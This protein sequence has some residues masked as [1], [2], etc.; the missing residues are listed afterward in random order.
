MSLKRHTAYNIIGAIVPIAVSLLT[1]PAYLAAVGDARF[2]IL[3]V[4]W[5]LLG[6]FGLFD[7]GLG[8]ATSHHIAAA[9]KDAEAQVSRWFWSALLTNLLLGVIG[10]LIIW[11][12]AS[13]YFG[14]V[15]VVD[16]AMRAEMLAAVPWLVL[17]VPVA[18]VT[19][20]MSGVLQG[21]NRFGRLNF[22]SVTGTV[23]FQLLPLG[24]AFFWSPS[25]TILLP[26]SLAARAIS[27]IW[28]WK[29]IRPLIGT[30]ASAGFSR[31]RAKTMLRFGG[32]VTISALFAPLMIAI[33]R[34]AIGAMISAA[35][36][37][38]YA[39]PFN[40]A[41][42]LT[43][44]GNSLGSALFP[45]L[46][47]LGDGDLLSLAIRSEKALMAAM[48]PV[49]VLSI[50]AIGPFL[51]LWVGP[52]FAAKSIPAA[53]V[54]MVGIFFDA[55][56]RVPLYTLRGQARPEAV[57]KVDLIQLLPYW[58][59]LYAALSRGALAGAAWAYVARVFFN[60]F[61]LAYEVG[62]LRKTCGWA[63]A[64]ALILIGAWLMASTQPAWH[65]LWI[66]GLFAAL[67]LAISL[68][69]LLMPSDLRRMLRDRLQVRWLA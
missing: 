52:T 46:S 7:L 10:G 37:S 66:G 68:S 32:W 31:D 24:A 9:G 41:D 36:V 57:A 43:I 64:S 30:G 60:Y 19:G 49:G 44:L 56:S 26:V 27:L 29:E 23:L 42:R 28:L 53:T 11:P 63:L 12:V 45:K 58:A 4:T 54:L 1:V 13:Y 15:I 14:H 47:A 50:F 20:V 34:F 16:K 21:L 22:I 6:Y 25:L 2:G 8:M 17:A 67:F 69:T 33:D 18:T 38:Y 3:A 61:L 35:A 40:L 5:L 59:L 48:L 39:V 55:V 51:T 62:S 65:S